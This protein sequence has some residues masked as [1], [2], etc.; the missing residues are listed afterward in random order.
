VATLGFIGFA[1][2]LG[3]VDLQTLSSLLPAAGIKLVATE[4]F[5]RTA[6][7]VA[8]QVLKIISAK[9]DAV[10]VGASATPAVLPHATLREQ[11]YKGQIY[12]SNAVLVPDFIR[13][14]GN[15][16]NGTIAV[17]S[18]LFVLDQLPDANPSK[19]TGLEFAKIWDPA[20]GAQTRNAFAGYS[21]D[22]YLILTK[23]VAEAQ[24]AVTPGT[25]EF[26]AALRDALERT[27]EVVG[28]TAVYT[29]S[30]ADHTG[31]DHRAVHLIRLENG[32]W[33]LMQ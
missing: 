1:D 17:T 3:E 13:V 10:Y 16:V 7:S 29:M 19:K 6:T 32:A 5:E 23:A 20:Y 15:T 18:P 8:A 21:Y 27:K 31:V 25:P 33:K 30:P 2:A 24:K 9:P 26:R 28:A 4:R 14:G 22:A 12:H 11:G